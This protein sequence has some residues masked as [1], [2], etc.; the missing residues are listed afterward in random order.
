MG[1]SDKEIREWKTKMARWQ[2]WGLA[3]YN[4]VSKRRQSCLMRVFGKLVWRN[5][6]KLYRHR[7]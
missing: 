3:F 1:Y 7:K 4:P 2:G 5:H 6:P